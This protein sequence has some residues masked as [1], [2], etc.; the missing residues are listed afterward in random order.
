MRDGLALVFYP[1]TI[2]QGGLKPR[3]RAQAFLAT[4]ADS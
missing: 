4:F 3:G 2:H 1:R